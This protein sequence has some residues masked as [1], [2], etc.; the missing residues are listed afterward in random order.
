MPPLSVASAIK[1][2]TRKGKNTNMMN[3]DN[4]IV[5][6]YKSHAE[7]EAAV[8]ELQRSGF[9][10]KKLSIVGRDYHTDENVVG[11]YNAGDRM[12][13]WGKAG[14]FW[15]G[16]WGLLFGSA[17][18]FIPGVGP[19]LVA[20]PL[21]AWI[22]GALEGAVVVGGLSAIGAGLYSLGIPKDSVLQYETAVKT[23]KFIL[24]AH[25]SPDETARAQEIIHR[26]SPESSGSHQPASTQAEPVPVGV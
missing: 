23:G 7:A 16:I 26:T 14:A 2:K 10:M 20:G 9:D 11:Y 8:K 21:V 13:Y 5:A 22:V 4:A 17:F 24:I 1:T 6:I 19:L 25:G 3:K 15:G 18:F 12:K